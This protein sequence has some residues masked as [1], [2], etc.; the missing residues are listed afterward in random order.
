[1]DRQILS[2]CLLLAQ[3]LLAEMRING[4]IVFAQDR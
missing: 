4:C 2:G 1:M 3:N